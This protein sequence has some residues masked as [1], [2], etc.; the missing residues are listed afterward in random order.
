MTTENIRE[1]C[2]SLKDVTESFPFDDDALVFK[3][4][5]KMFALTSLEDRTLTLKCDPEKAI[6]LR[7]QYT[8]VIPGYHMNKK[9]WNTLLLNSNLSEKLLKAW[10]V[11]S[12]GLV[13]KGLPGK[14][15]LTEK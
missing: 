2:L 10:I 8:A 7:E 14:M 12:Y 11:D 3:V 5:G 9:Y 15:R 13:V 4:K 1:F 6:E